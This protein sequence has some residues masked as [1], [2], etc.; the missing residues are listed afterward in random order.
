MRTIRPA[1]GLI[2]AVA[3]L[4]TACGA[5][6]SPATD[7]ETAD[8]TGI[9]AP[10]TKADV[11]ELGQ[12][13]LKVWADAGEKATLDDYVPA[14]EKKYPNVDVQ[15]TVKSFDDITKTVV[16]AM[17]GD[18]PPDVAQG[19]Q[20]Y[21]VDG[22]LVRA[23]LV[24]P[25]DDVA[26]AYG[27]E[28]DFAGYPLDQ[29]RWNEQGTQWGTGKLYG[30]APVTQYIGVFYNRELLAEAGVK[31]PQSYADLVAS[32]PKLKAKGTTPIEFGNSDKQASMHLFGSVAGRC[33]SAGDVN[34]WVAGKKG[35]TFATDCNRQAANTLRDWVKQGY[36]SSGYDGVTMDDAAVKFAKG[37]A[38]YFVGGDWLAQQ[39]SEHGK[40]FGFTVPTGMGGKRVTTGGSGMPWHVSAKTKATPAAVAFVAGLH[41]HAYAQSLVD[42][43]RVPIV[44]ADVKADTPLMTDDLT[45]ARK[46]LDDGG[47][48]A[49]LDWSTD[50]MYDE[51]GSRL[52][53]LLA[54]RI[55]ADGFLDAVQGNWT[56]F[57][58]KK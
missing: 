16:N 13:K 46:V 24:R 30:N 57:Q 45:T 23:R 35:T 4:S 28:K 55:G 33:Q 21:Q 7:D 14:F 22:A 40:Q 48:T 20:G 44:Q 3:A 10:V 12:V 18:S 32:L 1:L 41:E 8:A 2:A 52:Q 51:F 6:G 58:Q 27:W 43:V 54:G 25:L 19:N 31:P 9:T 37:D 36:L 17:N 50:T 26:K 38:A 15:L 42:Q 39:I 49:Y 11:D 29:F 47:Q 34:D 5:P 56:D 53:E